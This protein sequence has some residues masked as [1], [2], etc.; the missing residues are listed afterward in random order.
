M[1]GGVDRKAAKVAKERKE[2]GDFLD[3]RG[4]RAKAPG[5]KGGEVV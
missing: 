5:R 2:E 4:A 1:D 3:G